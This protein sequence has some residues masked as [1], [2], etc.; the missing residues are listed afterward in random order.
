MRAEVESILLDYECRCVRYETW[1]GGLG[2]TEE[3]L[4]HRIW[5]GTED[6]VRKE[7]ED[8]R[9]CH[10]IWLATVAAPSGISIGRPV[11]DV[12]GSEL[13]IASPAAYSSQSCSHQ[14]GARFP[15]EITFSAPAE[16]VFAILFDC[17]ARSK[18]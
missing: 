10:V 17:T 14:E 18:Q 9:R 4:R 2:G 11:Q 12:S 16:K 6:G 1:Q 15:R 7:R 8:E 5:G 3:L 13:E